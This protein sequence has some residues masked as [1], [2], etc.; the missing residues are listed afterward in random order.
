MKNNNYTTT[1]KTG[2]GKLIA[3]ICLLVF[4]FISVKLNAQTPT[5]FKNGGGTAGNTIPMGQASQKT[6]LLYPAT[7]FNTTPISGN[8]TKIY[9]RNSASAITSTYTDF[10]VLFVQ[11]TDLAFPATSFYTGLT[12][13]LNEVSY[14][15]TGNAT[16]PGWFEIPL[17]TPYLYDNT[18]SL[19]VEIQYSN[20]TGATFSTTT[21]TSTG[22]NRRCSGTSLV[23]TTGT[24]N[25]TWNDFG[26]D[27]IPAGGCTSP[28]TPGASAANPS[29][30]LC[31]GNNISLSL[32][33]NS[34]GSGQTYQWQS[35]TTNATPWTNVGSSQVTSFL[36]TPATASTYY[37][38]EVTCSG[39]T[40][41]STSVQV[42]VNS[43]FA[44]G[45]YTIGPAGTYT[46][47][48]AAVNALSCGIAGPVVFNV[49]AGS[50]PYN[51]QIT[52][53][54]IAGASSTN[55]ITFNCAG[56]TMVNASANTNARA[57]IKL[58]G[59][60]YITI[61][62]LTIDATTGTYGWGVHLTNQADNNTIS[63]CTFNLPANTIS[64]NFH[65]VIFSNS[66]T[67]YSTGGNS[68]NNL[69]TGNTINSGYYGITLYGLS[70]SINSGNSVL[71][72]T[73]NDVYSYPVYSVYNTN[74][75]ISGNNIQKPNRTTFT[76]SYGIYL[77]TSVSG[78]LVEK[79]RI[80]NMFG[81]SSTSTSIFYG[82]YH[83][84]DGTAGA[85][86][87]V[88]NNLIYDINHNG[89]IY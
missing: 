87:K 18:K 52:I 21:S 85:P 20:R 16:A 63:G 57:A 45:S 78:A 74:L 24:T 30:G 86:N 14:V 66:N 73:I 82:I 55:T 10:K 41:T 32:S 22:F 28:P 37:R 17:T 47:F 59:A 62:N 13:A 3:V 46:S 23:A 25:T 69:I 1:R 36:N 80:H 9:F 43:P 83:L 50:G 7:G 42:T 70:A 67:S 33:G 76:T 29:S 27:V 12:Q 2:L 48:T 65:A 5:Y 81:A 64:T 19:I 6:Q 26:M 58:D 75:T 15:I 84:A 38:C 35:S 79:N 72:N 11:N 31:V 4:A 56:V 68:N 54:V 39:N 49:A 61:N 44:G 40:Q 88:I 71:N 8:I 51:E 60:D 89:T 34:T 77:S 53:P